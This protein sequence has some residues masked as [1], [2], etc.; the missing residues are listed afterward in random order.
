MV[1]EKNKELAKFVNRLC[2]ELEIALKGF[3][4][5]K[6]DTDLQTAKKVILAKIRE[7]QDEHYEAMDYD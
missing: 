4:G 7:L 1:S 2:N 6:T 3:R 5:I